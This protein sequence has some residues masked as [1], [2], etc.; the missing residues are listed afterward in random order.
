[1]KKFTKMHNQVQ[2][3]G[4]E[5]QELE[6]T[7]LVGQDDQKQQKQHKQYMPK[8]H[9]LLQVLMLFD[10]QVR[11]I[12]KLLSNLDII[13]SRKLNWIITENYKLISYVQQN[14]LSED[15]I[16]DYFKIKQDFVVHLNGI[17]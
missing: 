17:L 11:L 9:T 4:E 5:I 14:N 6:H 7:L 8:Q 10:K 2:A 15:E 16:Q 12:K 3:L 13:K 1:M